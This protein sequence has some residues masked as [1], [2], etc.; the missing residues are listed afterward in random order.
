MLFW[1]GSTDDDSGFSIWS[2]PLRADGTWGPVDKVIDIAGART[3]RLEAVAG[4][5][6]YLAVMTINGAG[7]GVVVQKTGAGHWD[8]P[9]GL[10]P[11]FS[12]KKLAVDANRL[13]VAGVNYGSGEEPPTIDALTWR[14]GSWTSQ[15][16]GPQPGRE[17]DVPNINV[18]SATNSSGAHAFAWKELAEDDPDGP[19]A[20]VV[21]YRG[22]DEA[23][24]DD[25]VVLSASVP[26]R[27]GV[28][29]GDLGMSRT[30]AVTAAWPD[31]DGLLLSRR[32]P[33][34]GTWEPPEV[35]MTSDS[36]LYP[37]VDVHM[38][39]PALVAVAADVGADERLHVVSCSGKDECGDPTIL[40]A[41]PTWVPSVMSAG[42]NR[43]GTYLWGAGC[44]TE[45]CYPRHVMARSLPGVPE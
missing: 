21:A 28:F 11:A 24:F 34:D 10:P 7:R 20:L 38:T 39:G 44:R 37:V 41:P 2:R 30:G 16:L 45:E 36:D 12:A 8:A 43:S 5:D 3:V 32:D 9:L 31:T 22:V 6:R 15:R 25:P 42:P 14:E 1:Q 19:V 35:L 17:L 29:C 40:T 23:E 26:C 27:Y 33:D 18:R 4:G 13:V